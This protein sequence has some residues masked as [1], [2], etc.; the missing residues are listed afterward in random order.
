MD[1]GNQRGD[2]LGE[3]IV[4]P[5]GALDPSVRLDRRVVAEYQCS[6]LEVV[7]ALKRHR[8]KLHSIRLSDAIGCMENHGVAVLKERRCGAL[9]ENSPKQIQKNLEINLKVVVGIAIVHHIIRVISEIHHN[10]LDFCHDHRCRRSY[11]V[12]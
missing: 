8:N 6:V 4:E 1:L 7:L 9:S 12:R 11:L 3:E 2:E 10:L 5:E